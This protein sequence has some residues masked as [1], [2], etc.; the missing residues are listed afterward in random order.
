MEI[1]RRTFE[2]E[3][4][5]MVDGE[6]P[7]ITGYAAV[8]DKLSEDLGGFREKVA[9][10][11]FSKS[12]MKDDIRAL[13]N[14]DPNYVLGRNKAGTLEL[15]ED[16]HGLRIRVKVPKTQW[17]MDLMESIKRGDINQMSFGF[18]TIKDT[19]E[20]VGNNTER[21]LQEAQLFDVSPVTYPAYP[22]TSAAVRSAYESFTA[23]CQVADDRANEEASSQARLANR[24]LKFDVLKDQ[25][26]I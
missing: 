20:K 14:H 4:F 18:R 11:A 24:K 22:Q 9:S 8:F 23:E 6:E 25:T 16:G 26:K 15:E 10:G 2:V 3:E 17:A 19:W 7:E 13:F 21:T 12:L 1:E 5:R